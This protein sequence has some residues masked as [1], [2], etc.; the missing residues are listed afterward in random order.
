MAGDCG[1]VSG[2]KTAA[3]SGTIAGLQAS[4]D[5]QMITEKT[6][7]DLYKPTESKRR[8]AERFGKQMGKLMSLRSGLLEGLP[9]DTMVCRCEDITYGQITE[10]LCDGAADC[11]EVKAWTRGG[12]FSRQTL[13]GF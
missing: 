9:P 8:R 4:F 2:A 5:S 7:R 11:N 12:A 6:F 1:G 10:A 13:P 3:L